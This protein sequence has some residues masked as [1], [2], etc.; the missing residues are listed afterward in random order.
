MVDDEQDMVEDDEQEMVV[1]D[2]R[3]EAEEDNQEVVEADQVEEASDEEEFAEEEEEE[4][5]ED[6]KTKDGNQVINY[7]CTVRMA[8]CRWK[9]HENGMRALKSLE[10]HVLKCHATNAEKI[11][12]FPRDKYDRDC[13]EYKTKREFQCRVCKKTLRGSNA[14]EERHLKTCLERQEKKKKSGAKQDK[15]RQTK[16]PR[17]E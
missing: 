4:E 1:E 10:G 14:H 8:R 3:E 11:L 17:K 15:N 13:R 7:K 9:T 6:V 16:K 5:E 2:K 12:K